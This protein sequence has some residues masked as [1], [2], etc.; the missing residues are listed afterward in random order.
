MDDREIIA[1][2]FKRDESAVSELMNRFGGLCAALIGNIVRDKR[3]REEC[4]SSVMFRLWSSIPP[5]RPN[6]LTAY[7]AR[8]A[9][10]EA[11]MRLRKNATENASP[12]L[13]IDEFAEFLPSG[14]TV[15][16]EVFARAIAKAVSA[17]L[18]TLPKEE[19]LVFMRRYWY[20]DPV[21]DIAKRF[22]MSE[23]RVNSLLTRTRRSLKKQLVKE[24]FI[25][26]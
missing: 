7:V 23:K 9:R 3:D 15:E 24:G 20:M 19:R 21:K 18:G 6:D 26:E 5:A 13:P 1:L 16:D 17:H 4:L 12:A 2:L 14:K 11:L 22:G 8:S 10:N 25:N